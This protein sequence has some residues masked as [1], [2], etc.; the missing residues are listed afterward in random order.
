[1]KNPLLTDALKEMAHREPVY[2]YC[3]NGKRYD[4]GNKLGFLQAT[5]EYALR[6]EELGAD[7]YEYLRDIV[8][9][10]VNTEK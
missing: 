1:M 4:V 10:K 5:V 3:F 7:F 6:D 9:H 8:T 2:A